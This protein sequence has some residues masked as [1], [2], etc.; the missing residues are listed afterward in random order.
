MFE[1]HPRLKKDCIE[2]G[3]FPLSL[4]LMLNDANYPWFILVPM[5]EGCGGNI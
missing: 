1:L 3:R 2:V 5:R 4:L